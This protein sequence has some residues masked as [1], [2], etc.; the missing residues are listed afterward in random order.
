MFVSLLQQTLDAI[1]PVDAAAMTAATQRQDQLTKVPGSLGVLE[2]VGIKLAGIA[3]TCPPPVPEPAVVGVFAGDHGVCAQGVSPWPQDITVGMLMNMAAG[4][5]AINVLSRHA[6]ATTLLTDV[7]VAGDY[8]DQ[9]LIRRMNVRKG[10]ADLSVEPAMTREEAVAALEVGIATAQQALDA[11]AACLMTG[12][13]GIGNTTPSS[14]LIAVFSR[15]E[16]AAVTGRGA[17]ANDDMLAHKTEIIERALQL[18]QPD[19]S[20]PVG[21][22]AAVGGLEHAALA[23]F[24]LAGAARKVPVILDG[25]IACS[26][27]CVAV[28]LNED[29]RGY[30]ISGH[31]GVEPGIRTAVQHLGLES[32]VDL[33]L[34]L[35]EGTGAA[36]ALPMVQASAKILVEMATFEEAGIGD[37]N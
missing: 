14:A 25:V 19:A 20:D 32:L 1:T 6:G 30:L 24:I 17:G 3:G 26:A 27:A 22:L 4:G 5:A 29:V 34:R 23:G 37:D 13:M 33:R 35:G 21:V 15:A 18:H 28:G 2:R 10:T 31:A 16:V 11:G 9:P 7:G 8:P 36:L 12:E